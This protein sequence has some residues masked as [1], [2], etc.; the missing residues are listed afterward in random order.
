MGDILIKKFCFTYVFAGHYY[1]FVWQDTVKP[2]MFSRPLFREFRELI[3]TVKLK[4]VNVD[5][6]PTLICMIRCVGSVWF[7]FAKIKGAMMMLRVSFM[8]PEL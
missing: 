8:V 3:K 4:G 6:M 2:L 7:E 5:S 1:Y